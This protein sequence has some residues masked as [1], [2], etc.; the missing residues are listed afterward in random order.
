MNSRRQFI[1]NAALAG[2]GLLL[3][4]SV[5]AN[6][7]LPK[8]KKIIIIGAGFA[9]LMAAYE[10]DKKGIDFEILEARDRI[11]GRGFS[12]SFGGPDNLVVE[13]GAEWVGEDHH[14][15]RQ[16]C[17]EFNLHLD[18]NQLDTRAIYKGRFYDDLKKIESH[19]WMV[20]YE[21]LLADY[22]TLTP[23]QKDIL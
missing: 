2:G 15:L 20:T 13:L 7:V 6:I 19:E 17:A 14:L 12:H 16:L 5:F 9:G 22:K 18:N 11:G 3:S 23:E 4:S 8:R 10:L 21:K 1:R